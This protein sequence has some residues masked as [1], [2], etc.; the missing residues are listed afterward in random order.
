MIQKLDYMA[1]YCIEKFQSAKFE[2]RFYVLTLIIFHWIPVI[3]NEEFFESTH[4]K[5]IQPH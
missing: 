1:I 4:L 2:T 3:D 5:C